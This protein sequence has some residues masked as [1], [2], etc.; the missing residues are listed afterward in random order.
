VPVLVRRLLITLFVIGCFA[1]IAFAC[2]RIETGTSD[3]VA[4]SGE[5]PVEVRIPEPNSE[6][7]RQEAVGADLRPGWTG[8]LIL[9]GV[10]LPDDEVDAADLASTG[11]ITY[12]VGEG[13]AVEQ[14]EA[15]QNCL[16]VLAWR[17][18]ESPETARPTSWCFNV[19]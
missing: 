8:R 15:G 6:I 5:S 9:N 13:K 17:V 12:R 19:T 3:D 18:E 14:F 4:T 7:L 2:T 16:T 10:A 1:G 11:V